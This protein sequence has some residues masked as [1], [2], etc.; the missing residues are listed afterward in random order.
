MHRAGLPKGFTLIELMILLGIFG[1]GASV[2]IAS[3]SSYLPT[4]RLNEASRDFVSRLQKGRMEAV[5][6][7]RMVTVCFKQLAGGDPYDYVIYV[8]ADADL[9]YDGGEEIISGVR[10]VDYESVQFDTSQGGGD[11]LSFAA[12]DDGKPSF[13]WNSRGIPIGNSGMSTSGSLFLKNTKGD[14]KEVAV[15]IAGNI[16][17]R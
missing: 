9:E 10:F 7:N 13:A 14:A 1:I 8:D 5:K 4:Y 3:I 16:R 6:R 2:A 15:G 17:I 12:N 11:G